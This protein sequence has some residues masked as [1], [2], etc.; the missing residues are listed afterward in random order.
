MTFDQEWDNGRGFPNTLPEIPTQTPKSPSDCHRQV[1]FVR[2]PWGGDTAWPTPF[3]AGKISFPHAAPGPTTREFSHPNGDR[4]FAREAKISRGVTFRVGWGA[5]RPPGGA[6]HTH[7]VSILLGCLSEPP[8][9][10]ALHASGPQSRPR[11][12]GPGRRYPG[13]QSGCKSGIRET[14][15]LLQRRRATD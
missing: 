6:G 11:S 13:R 3:P 8:G 12:S 4:P 10:P 2:L 14:T 9:R 15:A 1:P 7:R 5:A